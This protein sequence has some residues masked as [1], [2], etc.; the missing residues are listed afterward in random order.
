MPH[1]KTGV[2][3]WRH[4]GQPVLQRNIYTTGYC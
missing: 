2:L 4:C 1:L 3:W